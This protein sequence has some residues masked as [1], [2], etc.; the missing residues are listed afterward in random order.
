MGLQQAANKSTK[1]MLRFSLPPSPSSLQSRTSLFTP[2]TLHSRQHA[3]PHP[4]AFRAS[5]SCDSRQQWLF[6]VLMLHVKDEQ[7][8]HFFDQHLKL[9]LLPLILRK[10]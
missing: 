6:S 3:S 4:G 8:E 10:M 7:T 2:F 5:T 9:N 1:E